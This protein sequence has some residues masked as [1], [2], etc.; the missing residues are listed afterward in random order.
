MS[1]QTRVLYVNDTPESLRT[2]ADFLA[3]HSELAVTTAASVSEGV[4]AISTGEFDCVLSDLSMT[5]ARNLEFLTE[6]RTRDPEIPFIL[7]TADEQDRTINEAIEKGADDYLS[8]SLAMETEDVLLRRI[9][10]LTEDTTTQTANGDVSKPMSIDIIDLDRTETGHGGVEKGE[11]NL[12][13]RANHESLGEPVA[14]GSEPKP[15]RYDPPDVTSTLIQADT[16]TKRERAS[17]Q[18]ILATARGEAPNVVLIRYK[19]IGESALSEIVARAN[20]TT[21]ISIGYTQPTPSRLESDVEIIRIDSPTDL[22]RLG[23]V[24]TGIVSGW[25]SQPAKSILCFDTVS[26]LLQYKT[27][28][29]V[30]QFLHILLAKLRSAGVT[31]Y[32]H[33]DHTA[34]SQ[35]DVNSLKPIFDNILEVSSDRVDVVSETR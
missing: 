19:R 5:D 33:L 32:F 10:Q 3:D 31:S 15:I 28:K 18:D 1:N 20:R 9:R 22:T 24:T 26:V 21:I 4:T 11:R 23:I 7:F 17:C 12:S 16:A 25:K 8:K 30:F 27:V 13:G 2:W 14:I 34:E 29:Q 6:V 35:Q